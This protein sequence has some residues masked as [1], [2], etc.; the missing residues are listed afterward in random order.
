MMFTFIQIQSIHVNDT[1]LKTMSHGKNL[2]N[3]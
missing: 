3:S 2:T 1:K